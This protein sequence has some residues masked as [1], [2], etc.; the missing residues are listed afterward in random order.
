MIGCSGSIP[1]AAR[2]LPHH[3]H[4]HHKLRPLA[5]FR[6]NADAALVELHHHLDQVQA[7]AGAGDV[8]DVAAAVVALEQQRQVGWRDAQALV[9]DADAEFP[10]LHA[11]TDA[12]LAALR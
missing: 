8:A 4:P 5:Q 10:A 11:R 3:R 9:L 2:P 7:D 12:D 1:A 6:F